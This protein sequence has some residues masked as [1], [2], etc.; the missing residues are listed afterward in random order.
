[1][2]EIEVKI[3]TRI[4][5]A[6]E[7]HVSPAHGSKTRVF[8]DFPRAAEHALAVACSCGEVVLDVCVYSETGA[9]S[10]GGDDAVESYREDPDASV[11]ERY[12]IKVNAAGRIA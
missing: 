9:F 7:Y 6:V 3:K 1:M 5:S 2:K 12:E 4:H 8:K 10:Y 11:F